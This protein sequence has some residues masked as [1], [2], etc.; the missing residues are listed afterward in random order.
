MAKSH[1]KGVEEALSLVKGGLGGIADQVVPWFFANMPDYYLR[2]HSVTEQVQHLQAIISGRVVTDNQA[3]RLA[4]PDGRK[5]TY[6]SPSA[7]RDLHGILAGMLGEHIETARIYTTADGQLGLNEFLLAPQP[8]A[9]SLRTSEGDDLFSAALDA[10]RASGELPETDMAA[11]GAFLAA[12]NAEYVEKFDPVRAARHFR[13]LREIGGGDDT[14][15]LI[16]Q[17]SAPTVPA[18]SDRPGGPG[19]PGAVAGG[20]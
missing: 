13:L 8:R 3:V 11:F 17:C 9:G 20:G 5:I 6:I 7:S 16:E 19:V 18:V 4:S 10:M 14:G 15:L 2:T 12:A 1:P